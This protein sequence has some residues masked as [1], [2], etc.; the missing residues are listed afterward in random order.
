MVTAT[1]I[2]AFDY[3]A[4]LLNLTQPRDATEARSSDLREYATSAEPWLIA[5]VE[6]DGDDA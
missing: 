3:V 4:A 2:E 5:E 1:T 6:E